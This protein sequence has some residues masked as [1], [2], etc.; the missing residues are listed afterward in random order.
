MII[1][2]TALTYPVEKPYT[3]FKYL[4]TPNIKVASA[5]WLPITAIPHAHAGFDMSNLRHGR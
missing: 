1:I 4:V 3:N 2:K 5:H